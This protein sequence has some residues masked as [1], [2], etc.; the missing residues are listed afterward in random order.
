MAIFSTYP[1][2]TPP[3]GADQVMIADS[4]AG[5]AQKLVS[6]TDINQSTE[7][8]TFTVDNDS[9]TGK[10]II[11]VA[12]GAADKSL[13]ITNE[14]LDND[15]I[16]TF[17][18]KTGTVALTSDLPLLEEDIIPI[19]F[20]ADGSVPPAA[21]EDYANTN[22]KLRV[23][24]FSGT[25]DNDI[26]FQWPVPYKLD[27]SVKPQFLVEYIVTDATGP[28]S[29]VIAFSL[30]GY[31]VGN[32]DDTNSAFGAAVESK[33]GSVTQ[34]TNARGTTTQS[35]DITVTNLAAGELAFFQLIRLATSTDTYAK[36][37]AITNIKLFWKRL[38]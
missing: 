7:S 34:A 12:L 32:G 29:E 23:R 18:N 5:G 38:T 28:S 24:K 14:T 37:L 27:T 10:I 2:K 36:D 17:P 9:T 1:V 31:S 15:R 26:I 4:G 20:C 8:N 13:T 19:E 25:A 21:V 6:I 3:A 16:A 33:T 35:G 11:D 30:A 22:A